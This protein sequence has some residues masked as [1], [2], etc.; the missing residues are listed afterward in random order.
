MTDKKLK[1]PV[2]K[3]TK[4][5]NPSVHTSDRLKLH[6]KHQCG[7]RGLYINGVFIFSSKT[8]ATSLFAFAIANGASADSIRIEFR[9]AY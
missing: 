5:L 7:E 2:M 3:R 4:S 8:S 1:K 6:N 9:S